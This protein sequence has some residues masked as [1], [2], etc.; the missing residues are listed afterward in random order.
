MASSPAFTPTY[1]A[2]RFPAKAWLDQQRELA[3]ARAA[4]PPDPA[5]PAPEARPA[6]PRRT[7]GLRGLLEHLWPR[8]GQRAADGTSPRPGRLEASGTRSRFDETFD[9]LLLVSCLPE[10]L[11]SW[12]IAQLQALV[13]QHA[14]QHQ[15]GGVA[16]ALRDSFVLRGRQER[17]PDWLRTRLCAELAGGLSIVTTPPAHLSRP[18]RNRALVARAEAIGQVAEELRRRPGA[19]P[20]EQELAWALG[21]LRG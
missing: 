17:R 3:A 12:L 5:H 6:R 9:L 4:A 21:R 2:R 19:A 14:A 10:R 1:P 18:A 7:G 11:H 15:A 13:A 20:L 16:A 8:P